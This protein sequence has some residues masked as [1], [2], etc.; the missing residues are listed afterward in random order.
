MSVARARLI[1]WQQVGYYAMKFEEPMQERLAYMPHY[2]AILLGNEGGK[3]A[4][5]VMTELAK[6]SLTI[7][8]A[9]R[10]APPRS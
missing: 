2:N 7:K 6:Y 10:K 4:D 3:A 1:Y 9:P 5:I 8:R